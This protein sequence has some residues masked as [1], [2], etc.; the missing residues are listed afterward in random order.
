M[1]Y[2]LYVIL[3]FV[4]VL[5]A[6]AINH[7]DEKLILIITSYNPDMGS[8][9]VNLEEFNEAYRS[10]D[11]NARIAI[12][13]LD[14][15]YLKDANTWD[16]RLKNIMDKYNGTQ[17]PDMIVLLGQEAWSTYLS[18]DDQRLKQIPVMGGLISRNTISLPP[19]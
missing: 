10:L 1:R 11:P 14:C 4:S 17:Q 15:L 3:F 9:Q 7:D 8:M 13:S 6:G 5:S 19:D 12:E 18:Q 2:L 16:D